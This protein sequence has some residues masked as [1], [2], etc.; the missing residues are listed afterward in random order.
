[1]ASIEVHGRRTAFQINRA[2][3]LNRGG[4]RQRCRQGHMKNGPLPPSAA[5][6]L[7]P[8]WSPEDVLGHPDGFGAL[9]VQ[10]CLASV[11]DWSIGAP[12][13]HN[14]LWSGAWG[15][16]WSR[17]GGEPLWAVWL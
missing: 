17:R 12:E 14:S 11:G 3:V 8:E 16:G 4:C 1:M 5:N 15:T 10:A 6:P 13:Q 2:G 7:N 9:A